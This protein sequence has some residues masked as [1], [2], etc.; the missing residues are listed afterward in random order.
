MHEQAEELG[1]VPKGRDANGKLKLGSL[2]E[3]R[4][5]VRKGAKAHFLHRAPSAK[6]APGTSDLPGILR[7]PSQS[8]RR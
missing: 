6:W 4:L 7:S 2:L 3:G 5:V 1:L 8:I